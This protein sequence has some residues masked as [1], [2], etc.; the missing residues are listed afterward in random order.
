MQWSGG[1][2]GS[3]LTC[4]V[5][6]FSGGLRGLWG[7]LGARECELGAKGLERFFSVPRQTAV[8]L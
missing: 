4:G 5:R 2:G 1:R 6:G 8:C 3:V 7:S